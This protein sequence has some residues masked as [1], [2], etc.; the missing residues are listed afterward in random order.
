M[1]QIELW[2]NQFRSSHSAANQITL[3]S[4]ALVGSVSAPGA[5]AAQVAPWWIHKL[6]PPSKWREALEGLSHAEIFA[7]EMYNKTLP[8][9]FVK[10]A[11]LF[12]FYVTKAKK[13]V[14]KGCTEMYRK[15]QNADYYVK[16]YLWGAQARENCPGWWFVELWKGHLCYFL[17]KEL[18]LHISNTQLPLNCWFKSNFKKSI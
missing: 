3:F 4:P 12:C 1:R 16:F 17:Q 7:A 9:L 13:D 2:V 15:Q 8:V 18:R 14:Q 10:T 6:N 5:N 11:P